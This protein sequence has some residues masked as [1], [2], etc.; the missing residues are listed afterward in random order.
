MDNRDSPFKAAAHGLLLGCL[1]P[2]FAWNIYRKR[3]LG[4]ILYTIFAAFECYH[5]VNHIQES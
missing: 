5:I 1:I 4:I 2:I 3:T